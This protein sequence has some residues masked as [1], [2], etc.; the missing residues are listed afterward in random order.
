VDS[1]GY[2]HVVGKLQNNPPESMKFVEITA[3]FY[4][5]AGK[6]VGMES[7]IYGYGHITTY[8]KIS[9]RDSFD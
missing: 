7:G 6:V 8:R 4:D 9:F 2:F 5:A 1:I 3:T